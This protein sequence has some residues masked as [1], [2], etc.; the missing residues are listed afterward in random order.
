MSK[1]NKPT[2]S[3]LE[4]LSILWDKENATVKEVHEVIHQTK[5]VGYTTTLKLMQIMNEKGLVTRNMTNKK[6]I[7]TP[8]LIKE[9][10]QEQYVYQLIQDLFNGSSAALVLQALE[11]NTISDKDF[12]AIVLKMEQLETKKVTPIAL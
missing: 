4:I 9:K 8:V 7:Y 1:I 5:S 2:E 3:E 11:I 12:A 6:H 10:I